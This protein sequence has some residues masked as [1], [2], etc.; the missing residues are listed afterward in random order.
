MFTLPDYLHGAYGMTEISGTK[1]AAQSQNAFVLVGTAPVNTVVGGSANVNKPI[2]VTNFAEAKK[3]FGYS[4]NW[5]DFTLCEAMYVFFTLNGVGPLVLINVLDPAR[6]KSDQTTTTSL[7]PVSG[8]IS[9]A[10][11]GNIILESL[12][13][14]TTGE[15]AAEKVL[16]VD[17]AATY[18]PDRAVLLITEMTTG[19]LGTAALTVTYDTVDPSKVTIDD[20][21]GATDD[22][23]KNTGLYAIRNVYQQ[24]GFVPS[25][26]LAPGFSQIP[27]VHNAMYSVSSKVNK[28]WD[29]YMMVDL[30]L[31]DE[32]DIALTMG[33]AAAWKTTNG[34]THENETTYFPMVSGTDGRKYHISTLA[35]AN[36]QSLLVQNDGIPYKT[37]SNTECAVIENLYMGEDNLGRYWDDDMVN[38]KLNKN[39][40]ASATYLGG[41]WAIWGCHSA[42]YDQQN[43]TDIN[44]SETNRMMLY[45]LSNDFQHR[46]ARSADQPMTRNDIASIVAEEQARLDALIKTGALTYGTVQLDYEATELSDLVKGDYTFAFSVTTTPIAKS[47]TAIVS[48]TDEGFLTYFAN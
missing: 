6:H 40:I 45:Y 43:A 47:M 15:N 19:A 29:V 32:N 35:A 2:A 27:D 9:I 38:E 12:K 20:V 26:L 41:R 25:Y 8:R 10:A 18:N 16:G 33:S 23:G 21:I 1:L 39:G 13:L 34:Y 7:T 28:H 46:R 14:T 24:T 42:D 37:A 30:P 4:E 44:I 22:E 5:A 31:V 48:W 3:Y 11:A 36:F 17:Y